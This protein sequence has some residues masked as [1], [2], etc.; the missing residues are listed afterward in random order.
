M[1]LICHDLTAPGAHLPAVAANWVVSVKTFRTI[2]KNKAALLRAIEGN[3][4]MAGRA[5]LTPG[6]FPALDAALSSYATRL[7]ELR[8]PLTFGILKRRAK[9]LAGSMGVTHFAGS[10]GWVTR[11]LDRSGFA[12]FVRLHGEAGSVDEEAVAAEMERVRPQ[13]SAFHPRNVYNEDESGFMYQ[14]LP[15][16]TYLSPQESHRAT[17]G[18]K[19]MKNKE[20]ITFAVCCNATGC[21]ILP[22]FFIGKSAVPVCFADATPEERSLYK[23]QSNAWMVSFLFEHWLTLIWYPAKTARSSGPWVLLLDK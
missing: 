15:N 8:L 14:C 2:W 9:E 18:T 5:R 17:R 12:G 20:R 22:P 4:H 6:R 21:H 19:G 1:A 23:A 11:W 3:K 7:R 16:G 10:T 13:L